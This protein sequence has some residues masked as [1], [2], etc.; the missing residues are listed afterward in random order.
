MKTLKLISLLLAA[1]AASPLWAHEHVKTENTA[2]AAPVVQTTEMTEGE[3]R[4][5]DRDTQ[6]ITI[7][8][9]MAE[10]KELEKARAKEQA[11]YEENVAKHK[12]ENAEYEENVAKH[13]IVNA[14]LVEEY[15]IY[16]RNFIT[17][18]PHRGKPGFNESLYLQMKRDLKL[19]MMKDE[20]KE[21]VNIINADVKLKATILGN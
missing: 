15:K 6:I 18:T 2:V 10:G 3:V 17:L 13:K 20:Q 21:I 11:E 4:K 14:K 19:V 5:V 8:R 7:R 9:L 12:I 16:I 1:A